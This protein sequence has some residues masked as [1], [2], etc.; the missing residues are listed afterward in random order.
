MS[1]GERVCRV[2][3]KK[4]SIA[5]TSLFVIDIIVL[6]YCRVRFIGQRS[7]T[8]DVMMTDWNLSKTGLMAIDGSMQ[9]KHT[10]AEPLRNCTHFREA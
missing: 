9:L 5:E 3:C 7:P 2:V 6:W 1:S 8:P 10:R 4:T